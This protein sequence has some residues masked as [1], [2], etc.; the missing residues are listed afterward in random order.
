MQP[1]EFPC[2]V[3]HPEMTGEQIAATRDH[4]NLPDDVP[5]VWDTEAP[6][7]AVY[8]VPEHPRLYR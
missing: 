7:G 3:A 4:F 1:P 2:L 6:L 5:V 8:L